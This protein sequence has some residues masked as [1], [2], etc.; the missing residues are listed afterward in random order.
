[1]LVAKRAQG[2]RWDLHNGTM[3]KCRKCLQI[4]PVVSFCQKPRR[5]VCKLCKSRS[6]K[7]PSLKDGTYT[8]EFQLMHR[9]RRDAMKTFPAGHRLCTK[10][11]LSLPCVGVERGDRASCVVPI[12]CSF[13]MTIHNALVVKKNVADILK[14]AFQSSDFALYKHLLSFYFKGVLVQPELVME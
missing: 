6:W 2:G 10:E 4:L 12:D 1:M 7:N 13:P 11:I 5:Y 8:W 3:R 14:R 9:V